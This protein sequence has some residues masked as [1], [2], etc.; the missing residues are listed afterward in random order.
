MDQGAPAVVD[1]ED[2]VFDGERF[3][4]G[5]GVGI[6]YEH[7]ARYA[8]AGGVVSGLDVLDVG[9]GEGYGAAWLSRTAKS[10]RAFDL[11]DAAVEHARKRYADK[12]VH[13]DIAGVRE[14]FAKATPAS[15]DAVVAFELI[16]HLE[17]PDQEFLLEGIRRVLRPAGFA[18]ISTPDKL[19]Y[20]DRTL[21]TNPF[22]VR[23]YYRD[24]FKAALARHFSQVVLYDQALFTGAAIVAPPT[25]D[26][27][28]FELRWTDLRRNEAEPSP[29]LKLTGEYVVAVVGQGPLPSPRN[30][31]LADFSRKLTAES[32]A[33]ERAATAERARELEEARRA[34]EGAMR[35][36]RELEQQLE[37]QRRNA[38]VAEDKL[39]EAR[40]GADDFA[41]REESLVHLEAERA[42][43]IE[44]LGQERRRSEELQARVSMLLAETDH[45]AQEYRGS[46]VRVRVRSLATRKARII[47]FLDLLLRQPIRRL[48]RPMRAFRAAREEL[49]A[50]RVA[51][52]LEQSGLFDA[53]FY[54]ARYPDVASAGVDPALHYVTGGAAERRTPHPLFDTGFY[55][56]TNPD[57]LRSGINPLHHYLLSGAQEG[58]RPHPLFDSA[59]YLEHNPD[60]SASGMN[61]L[62]HFTRHGA[63]E[64]RRPNRQFDPIAYVRQFPEARFG[65]GPLAHFARHQREGTSSMAEALEQGEAR[66]RLKPWAEAA[67]R[68]PRHALVIDS[69]VLTPDRDSGSVTTLQTMRL[70]QE[71]GFAVTYMP[72]DL[73]ADAR[74]R[75]P[76]EDAGF[77]ALDRSELFTID[78]L[79]R[80]HGSMFEVVVVARVSVAC[81]LVERLRRFCPRASILFETMDLHYLRM[82]REAV[83]TGSEQT[84]REAA[85]T[86]KLELQIARSSDAVLVHSNTEQE[87]LAREAPEALS[88]VIPYVLDVRGKRNGFPDRTDLMFLGGFRHQPNVDAVLHLVR[89][90]LPF[91]HQQ[92]PGVSLTI[93]GSDPPPEVRALEGP[94]VRVVG[95]VEDLGPSFEATRVMVAPL[96]YGAGYKGKVAMS[97]AY[98]VPAVLTS[99]AAEGMGLTDG[100]EVLVADDPREFA[101]SVVRLYGDQTLWEKLS[102]RALGFAAERFSRGGVRPLFEQMLAA[103][104]VAPWEARSRDDSIR[105]RRVPGTAIFPSHFMRELYRRAGATF[106]SE[107]LVPH[108]VR[109]RAEARPRANRSQLI[110]PGVLRLLMAGRIV[111]FKGVHTAVESLAILRD[112]LAGLEARL[113]IVGDPSDKLYMSELRRQIEQLGLSSSIRFEPPVAEDSLFELFQ[114]HDLLL[115]P[116]LFEPFALT[117]ILA[118]EAG[119]P[120]IA[121]SAGGTVDLVQDHASGLLVPPADPERLADAVQELA[122]RPE[123]RVSLAERGAAAARSL[124]L[125]RMLDGLDSALQRAASPEG[126]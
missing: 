51:E 72:A 120:T 63:A 43:A 38:Q 55:L 13:F 8:L 117:L 31:L 4:P 95:Y 12:G 67:G 114:Q 30:L 88:Y 17:P 116:S 112:R 100:S 81:H 7:W 115:F 20:T 106:T 22:H 98:G 53:A 122:I 62:V 92:L 74:Y 6:A 21:R 11:D 102:D 59:Y 78:D 3:I 44:E 16:E 36:G 23:E 60:I 1:T 25:E 54:L 99:I 107:T 26:S 33:G 89:D 76:L 52:Q 97:L 118:L 125:D 66:G 57:V 94:S 35:H 73:R 110:E 46:Q 105:A 101:R 64:G 58:R 28:L 124:T 87:L 71:L 48:F 32:L 61:P 18:L 121:S 68:F 65:A 84:R 86:K 93:V 79:L 42:Q 111:R 109:F 69:S 37:A 108:G 15:F 104:G 19:L 41:H 113:S 83:V 75:Q 56:S 9:C 39:G 50:R 27:K 70:L 24:E 14:F 5:S 123:L 80:L 2:L 49:D 126:H 90:I 77:L 91:I 10:V 34:W 119:I 47:Q 85:A 29:G 82:E 103:A 40:R 96:R 45:I